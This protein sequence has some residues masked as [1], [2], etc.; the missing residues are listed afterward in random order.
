MA[1]TG[2]PTVVRQTLLYS[3]LDSRKGGMTHCCSCNTFREQ[4]SL[5]SWSI[6]WGE[7]EEST[8]HHSDLWGLVRGSGMRGLG[9]EQTLV[10]VCPHDDLR[11][12]M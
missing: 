7:G 8:K 1:T 3:P 10:K 6:G 5:A 9:R 12:A 2:Q 4:V 11:M